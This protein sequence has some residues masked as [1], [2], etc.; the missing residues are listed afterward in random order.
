MEVLRLPIRNFLNM[1]ELVKHYIKKLTD[2]G[3]PDEAY[4]WEA[5]N[6]F[7]KHWD[8]EAI[9]FNAMFLES[10]KQVGNLL[11]QNSWGYIRSLTA[12]FPEETREMFRE[13]YD[14]SEGIGI[15]I[16]NFQK[17]AKDLV[18]RVKEALGKTKINHQQD[19]RTI[20][21]YLSFKFPE[22]YYLY[23]SSF[24]TQLCNQL[25]IKPVETGRKYLHYL[26]LVDDL[27]EQYIST[28]Q[29]IQQIHQEIYP[30]TS[31]NDDNLI[32]Q[33]FLYTMLEKPILDTND[34]STL[35]LVENRK[36]WLF[37]P[38]KNAIKFNEFYEIGEI[39]MGW[40]KI[41][42]LAQYTSLDEIRQALYAAYGGEGDK[43]N[44]TTANW[45]FANVMDIGDIVIIKKGRSHIL[46]YGL[47]T[48]GYY[49]DGSKSEFTSRRKIE[50]KKKGDWKVENSLVL[51]TLTDITKYPS[52]SQKFNTYY[53]ELMNLMEFNVE[54]SIK[55]NQ[56][57]KEVF[58][59]NQILYGPPG[60]GKTYI[61]KEIAVKIA[62]PEFKVEES[63]NSKEI[64]REI[65]LKYQELYD[66]GQI[67][68][69]TFHQSFSYEDF[70]EGIKPLWEKSD[71]KTDELEYGIEA[72]I[73]MRC[74][75]YAAYNCYK[76]LRQKDTNE[77]YSFDDLYEAFIDQYREVEEKPNFR[78]ITGREVEIFEINK[79]DS[80]RARAKDSKAT[81]VAP[82]TKENLQ[83]LYDTFD[84]V[85]EIKNLQQVRDAVGVS[86]RITEFYAIFKG[87]K[88]FEKKEY[89][90]LPKELLEIDTT[91][92][93]DAEII[94]KFRAGVFDKA[95]ELYSNKA[96]PVV[97]IIDEINRGNV[98]S[99]FGELIT[100][101]EKD[102]RLGGEE[103][104]RVQL[105]Y[106]K[107]SFGVPSNL[108][109]IGTMNTADR[110]VEALD[111]ALR[112][113]FSFKEIMPDPSL[114][115]AIE[116]DGFNLKEVLETI[117]ER[118]EFL[119]DRDHT[120]GHSYFMDLESDDTD[121]L[122]EVFKNKVIPLLQEYFYHDYEKIALILGSGFVKV[123][124]NH[125]VKFPSIEGIS[126]PDQVTLCELVNDIDD[127]EAA[128]LKLLNRDGE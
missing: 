36:Y 67:V 109:I 60:T 80:I 31:W 38:G 56:L 105:P 69:T 63:L 86:P 78:T 4:K 17:Q 89:K 11:Y 32:T 71:D 102:K 93:D 40:D 55:F 116:F 25:H 14:E 44:D 125:Q 76:L 48:S 34:S 9:D 35:Q 41:G 58:P 96:N 59:L 33:N 7:Q 124:T 1:K 8:I 49:Y 2:Q 43:R 97:L 57:I 126:R 12:N 23:K 50:W 107:L 111:T 68:F 73:F 47:V 101:I 79:N 106:S 10:F 112:R 72:G 53:D 46:G 61:S 88:N 27:N 28:N 127:I 20:S 29:D 119:L 120:I 19:E 16:K 91:E 30:K 62:A 123:E 108:Y 110:S 3:D 21:V 5:I 122:E 98:S 103:K 51:K 94:K 90:N 118:I 92:L 100:L 128:V 15:R 81:H 95:F 54:S 99:I 85:A 24:Y 37:A 66:K 84:S 121:G 64:R 18:P 74:C 65:N 117:N 39:G 70:V 42:D 83:K 87:I 75:A 22:K 115:E 52:Y 13:L 77:K 45:E 26:K 113:R 114:I 82:L 104:L 6:H